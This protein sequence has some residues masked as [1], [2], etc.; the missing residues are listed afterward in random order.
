MSAAGTRWAGR[1]ALV[2][3]SSSGTG[4][5]IAREFAR[6][7]AH[8]AVH[9]RRDM[10]AANRVVDGIRSEGHAATAFCAD[11]GDAA[12]ARRLAAE[13]AERL[14]PVSILVNN[15]G[16]F[17]DAPFLTLEERDWDAVLAVNLK[18]PF[19]LVQEVAPA[20]IRQGW[21]RIINLGATSSLVRSHSIYGLAKA[22]VIHLTESLALELAPAVTVNAIV[23]SQ[24]AS[25]RTDTMP[26]YKDAAIAGT[27]L[28]R[29]V[30]EQEIAKMAARM[31]EAEFDFMTGRAIILDG[32]RTLP[33]FPRLGLGPEG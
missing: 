33:R 16:P 15:A 29:L 10:S 23:P 17:A 5:E 8:V 19:L 32:G 12:Q 11:L 3:G 9:C 20:M 13:V 7:G 24:I 25:P 30:T 22:A 31:C 4:A 27:P 6:L 2:T 21:G 28:G 1:V 26:V 18:A 14:G